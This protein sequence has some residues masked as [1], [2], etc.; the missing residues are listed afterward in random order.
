[1]AHE[2]VR[3]RQR[4][5]KCGSEMG[6]KLINMYFFFL[7]FSVSFLFC[8]HGVFI[9]SQQKHRT[10]VNTKDIFFICCFRSRRSCCLLS[11]F[12]VDIKQIETPAYRRCH[13]YYDGIFYEFFSHFLHLLRPVVFTLAAN[14]HICT[15]R[16]NF[17][18][19]CWWTQ[20]P[21]FA[22][23]SV[24]PVVGHDSTT[25]R[26]YIPSYALVFFDAA[27]AKSRLIRCSARRVHL[28]CTGCFVIRRMH[29]L[30]RSQIC[31]S[32][33]TTQ[34]KSTKF[35]LIRI[36]FPLFSLIGK[37]RH[38]IQW[39]PLLQLFLAYVLHRF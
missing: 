5:A 15:Q 23:C 27:A 9:S 10:V 34:E 14:S 6:K 17:L 4:W 32:F 11:I 8:R 21:C 2:V 12:I 24:F 36:S 38:I 20:D 31:F 1:M 26:S 22:P 30:G 37:S 18:S 28:L 39:G 29:A 35:L 25:S 13:D 16:Q 7:F 19:G 33:H 3:W